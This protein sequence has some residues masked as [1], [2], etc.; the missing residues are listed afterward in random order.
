MADTDPPI[1]QPPITQEQAAELLIEV[2]RVAVNEPIKPYMIGFAPNAMPTVLVNPPGFTLAN[3]QTAVDA[4]IK[5]QPKPQRRKGIY[6]AGDVASFLSWMNDN[7]DPAAPVFA[8]GAEKLA[9]DWADPDLCLIGIANYSDHADP[10]WHDLTCVYNFP[11]TKAWQSWA[12]QSGL[13]V[14]QANFAEFIE[15]H[16][17]E[18]SMPMDGETLSEPVTRMI[19]ALGGTRQVA[20][21]S[22]MYEVSNGIK[23]TVKESIE[24]ELNRST[25]EQTLIFTEEHTGKGARPVSVPKFFFIR[26]PIF[27]G[28]PA[29]LLGVH[30]RYRNQGGGMVMWS[31]ELFAPDLVVKDAFDKACAIVKGQRRLWLGTPDH[32]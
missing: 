4:F 24:V 12:A 2:P 18:F 15:N 31:Y 5:L 16:L 17:Y 6:T 22:R 9:N 13:W 20:T 21:P 25:G 11:I 19:E 7:C 30:L 10:A 29:T 23:I 27:F 26:V 8:A 3:T 1:T 32:P 28:E 14:N